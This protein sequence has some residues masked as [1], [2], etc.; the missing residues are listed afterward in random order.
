[1]FT[2]EHNIMCIQKATAIPT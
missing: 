2:V 1:M